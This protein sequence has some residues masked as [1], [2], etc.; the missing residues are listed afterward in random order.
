MKHI[1]KTG[2]PGFGL[3]GQGEIGAWSS[4]RRLPKKESALRRIKSRLPGTEHLENGR[5]NGNPGYNILAMTTG[6]GVPNR[7]LRQ[8]SSL[9][10]RRFLRRPSLGNGRATSEVKT[11]TAIC[12]HRTA[13]GCGTATWGKLLPWLT[14]LYMASAQ[15][16]SAQTAF[17]TMTGA[18]T[19]PNGLAVPGAR[20]KTTHADLNFFWGN[21]AMLPDRAWGE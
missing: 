18:T 9:D 4:Q 21:Q 1:I 5:Q 20:I 15:P 6:S 16:S 2:L 11:T 8:A 17:A 12:T 10:Q 14:L 13:A 19:D 3:A 7:L